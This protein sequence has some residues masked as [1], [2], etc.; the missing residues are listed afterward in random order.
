MQQ[1]DGDEGAQRRATPVRTTLIWI[2]A[3]PF[4]LLFLGFKFQKLYRTVTDSGSSSEERLY[5]S[6]A[7]RAVALVKER[8]EVQRPGLR[9]LEV[10]RV[11]AGSAQSSRGRL[12]ENKPP[13]GTDHVLDVSQVR[14]CLAENVRVAAARPLVFQHGEA[15]AARFS[16]RL[17]DLRS[18]CSSFR[19]HEEDKVAAER[20]AKDNEGRLAAEGRLQLVRRERVAQIQTRLNAMGFNAGSP[21][22]STGPATNAAISAFQRDRGMQPDGMAT[23]ALLVLL[24]EHEAADSGRKP[25]ARDGLAGSPVQ[26]VSRPDGA[27]FYPQESR[28]QG[29]DGLV[30]VRICINEKGKEDGT[31]SSLAVIRSSGYEELDSAAVKMAHAHEFTPMPASAPFH[32]RCVIMPVEFS[33]TDVP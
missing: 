7:E 1:A 20:Y 17:E 18:R 25:R 33:L 27:P 28:E 6:V 16:A 11:V 31:A 32:E 22:G 29:Q 2:A 8:D 30:K 21:D 4:V 19:L 26:V 24:E 15:A 9:E 5:A 10:H 23:D 12:A 14:Y 13:V 3:V